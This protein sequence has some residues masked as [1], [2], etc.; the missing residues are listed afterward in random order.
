MATPVIVAATRTAIGTLGGAIAQ[1]PATK[2]GAVAVRE[3]V[4]RAKGVEPAQVD[5]II[6]GHVLP[7]GL[8]LNPARVAALESGVPKETPSYGVNKACGSG[9]KAVV[10]AAQQIQLDQADIV[11]AGGM[12]SMSGA[13]YIL[14]KARFG[15]RL[16]HDELLDSMIA[17]GL[18]CPI[19]LVHM[20]VT[21]EN[22]AAKYGIS[23]EE[24]DEFAA[25]SQQKTA[26][27]QKGG[28]FKAEIV[29]IEIPAKKGET[30]TFDTD[31][32]PRGDTTAQRLAGLR[33][34]FKKDA[35][36]VTAG[37]ASGIND[38]GAAVV[39]MSDR[40]AKELKLTPLATI[41]AYASA[42]VDPSIMGM[43][44]WPACERVLERAKLR[45]EEIDLW[46]LNEAFAAQSLGVLREL[47]IPK[48]RVNV[49]GGAIA[50]G[51]PIGA[52]GAR[53]L[54]TLLHAMQDRDARLG[55]ASLCIGG[56]QGIAML[57]ERA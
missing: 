24:Q 2:L 40:K 45:R 53:V 7:A 51:H 17:D 19:T 44:P 38:G 42:G 52:S 21:A 16:G 41:R 8:G 43:G 29:P 4:R 18:T 25:E 34:A 1:L 56:G 20:G 22:I 49:N 12:E 10:L 30:V 39:V 27:A 13:P 47:R 5:E 23:R 26:A 55:V 32:H 57:V 31:E 50:L 46:E 33:P 35:G 28:K 6:L 37:N 48:N 3:A 11:V 14:K 36:T 15:V 54:V 9:L